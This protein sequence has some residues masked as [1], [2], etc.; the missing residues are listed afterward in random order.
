[1]VETEKNSGCPGIRSGSGPS[2]ASADFSF[3]SAASICS[4]LQTNGSSLT[5]TKPRNRWSPPPSTFPVTAPRVRASAS[6]SDASRSAQ[7]ASN[8]FS[9]AARS[10]MIANTP[11][12]DRP[13]EG[14]T[15]RRMMRVKVRRKLSS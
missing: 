4:P 12:P 11:K 6:A 7:S 10:L 8:R 1:M 2:E 15:T 3:G 9:T 13:A 5:C 14:S